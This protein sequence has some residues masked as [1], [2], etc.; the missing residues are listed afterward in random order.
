VLFSKKNVYVYSQFDSR[1]FKFKYSK[2]CLKRG[3]AP[4]PAVQ[5]EPSLKP[6]MKHLSNI[7]TKHAIEKVQ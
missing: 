1:K 6:L 5:L 4:V 2:T 3:M 7:P